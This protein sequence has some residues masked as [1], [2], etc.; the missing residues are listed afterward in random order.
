MKIYDLLIVGGGPV[1]LYAAFYAGMRGLSVGLIEAFD[2]VGGQ[3][4]HLYPE[5]KIYDV[6]GLPEISGATLIENLLKQLEFVKADIFSGQ[7]VLNIQ[8]LDDLFSVSTDRNKKY[9]QA[10]ENDALVST[11]K[12]FQSKAI[13]LTTGAGLIAP[14]KLGIED[15]NKYYES[16]KISYFIKNLADFKDKKVAVLGGGDSALDWALMLLNVAKEVHLI[17][18]R[19]KFRAHEKTVTLLEQSQV[20]LHIP[21]TLSALTENEIELNKVK[22]DEKKVLSVDK[23]LVNYGF[24]TNQV[25]L[26][27]Q[28]EVSRSNRILVNREMQTNLAGVFAAGDGADYEGKVP[29]ISVGFGEAVIAINAMSKQIELDHALKKGHSSSLFG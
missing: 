4:E 29:L 6:A 2:Q 28:L 12:L 11:D 18:R 14:R 3:P 25:D 21:Y 15:E 9:K 20:K 5:K 23:I 27:E 24:L 22:S 16:G 8:K 1:G 26:I 17:H 13:L 10:D 19:P 7:R